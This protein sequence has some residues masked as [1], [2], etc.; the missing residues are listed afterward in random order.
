MSQARDAE[1]TKRKIMDAAEDVFLEKGMGRSALSEISRKAGV[2][3]S[4]IHHHF[5]SKEGLWREV[6]VRRFSAYAQQQMAMLEDASPSVDLL[7]D[8]LALYFRFL[9]DNPQIIR[10]LAWIF[11]EKEPHDDACMNLDRQLLNAGVAKLRQGQENGR[12]RDDL[13]PRI[14]LFVFMALAQHWFHDR[15]HMRAHFTDLG[16]DVDE[17]YLKQATS[18][19]LHGVSKER[20]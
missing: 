14:I 5:G 3:K 11:L 16:G 4:L 15:D 17:L 7:R 10:V 20:T 12:L 8:S 9:R 19:F 2:T 1:T 6:K 13:D 18:I